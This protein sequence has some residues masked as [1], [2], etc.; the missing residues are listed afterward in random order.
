MHIISRIHATVHA[1]LVTRDPALDRAALGRRLER[2]LGQ[3]RVDHL[4]EVGKHG[5]A[6]ARAR[7]RVVRAASIVHHALDGGAATG[8]IQVPRA[9]TV[10]VIAL[11]GVCPG[12]RAGHATGRRQMAVPVRVRCHATLRIVLVRRVIVPSGVSSTTASASTRIQVSG[13]TGRASH[14][15]GRLATAAICG[16]IIVVVLVVVLATARLGPIAS[17][18]ARIVASSPV[19]CEVAVRAHVELG[20]RFEHVAPTAAIMVRREHGGSWRRILVHNEVVVVVVF[21]AVISISFT[22]IALA[23]Q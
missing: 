8:A 9:V 17:A 21:I 12:H 16:I 5:V 11:L 1:A 13:H 3:I 6:A 19:R 15:G 23:L 18:A 2:E 4:E 14:I 22:A 20:V 10:T 7:L